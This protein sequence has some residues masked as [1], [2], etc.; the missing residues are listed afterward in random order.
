MTRWKILLTAVALCHA[1]AAW[2]QFVIAIDFDRNEDVGI[3][4]PQ[5]PVILRNVRRSTLTPAERAALVADVQRNYDNGVGPGKVKV[6]DGKAGDHVVIVDG[7]PDNGGQF[8]GGGKRAAGAHVEGYS[9]SEGGVTIANKISIVY[10]GSY[11]NFADIPSSEKVNALGK[12]AGHET[13]HGF[14][15]QHN[16]NTPPDKMSAGVNRTQN[17]TSVWNFTPSDAGLLNINLSSISAFTPDYAWSEDRLGV[18]KR[19]TSFPGLDAPPSAAMLANLVYSGPVGLLFGVVGAGGDF[20]AG[21]AFAGANE[22]AAFS[23]LSFGGYDLAFSNGS[24]IWRLSE[25]GQISLSDPGN[26]PRLFRRADLRFDLPVGLASVTLSVNPFETRGGFTLG[27]PSAIPEPQVWFMLVLGFG[28][29]GILARRKRQAAAVAPMVH[30]AEAH[31][32]E[33]S[34]R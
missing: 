16:K 33:S 9:L 22:N 15:L 13:G 30:G 19:F 23:F 34:A 14:G 1:A 5:G 6:I 27:N 7:N 32:R 31:Q 25:L 17:R 29:V 2:A 21:L 4:G 24:S 18:Y 10:E 26:N 3:D 28:G 12:H 8:V 11:K 20:R